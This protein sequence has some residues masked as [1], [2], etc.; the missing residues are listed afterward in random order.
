MGNQLKTTFLLAGMTVLIMLAGNLMGGRQGMFIALLLAAGMNFFSYWYSD[1]MV[2][3]M[4]RAREVSSQEAPELYGMVQTLAR[5]AGLPMPK[6][7]I[8]P[9]RRPTPLPRGEIPITPWWRLPRDC[10][11]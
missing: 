9:R 6:V 1:K 7:Y 8:I 11:I 5:Q 2:L 4:Y 3:K 10:S